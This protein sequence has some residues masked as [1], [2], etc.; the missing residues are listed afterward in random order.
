MSVSHDEDGLSHPLAELPALVA[1]RLDLTGIRHLRAHLRACGTCRQELV[2]IVGGAA[3]LELARGMEEP[4]DELPPLVIESPRPSATPARGAA[5]PSRRR[6]AVIG[7]LA[8]AAVAA[9]L[10]VSLVVFR[11]SSPSTVAVAFAPL[12]AS[13]DGGTVS[14]TTAGPE[15]TMTVDARLQA[16]ADG[17]F[18]EVWLLDEA[19]GRM[20]SVGVLPAEGKASFSLPADLVAR[21]DAVD[22][23]VEPDDGVAAHSADS[24]L[25]ARYGH[26]S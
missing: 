13:G 11:R 9:V 20:L 25:R 16:A 5:R 8:A 15:R 23:S 10:V 6:V 12:A 4:P 18:Y 24:V 21:Y 3:A 1:G 22:V 26:V 7:G 17:S 19:S 2:E 14:M